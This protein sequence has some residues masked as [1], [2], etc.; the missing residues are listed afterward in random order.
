MSLASLTDT[1]RAKA[2]AN[3]SLGY[4]IQFDLGDDGIIFWD[5]TQEPAAI[6][7]ESGEADT[8][9]RLSA[10]DL[11]DLLAGNL[12]PTMA[13]MTGRL[14]VEGSLGVAMK[15]SQYMED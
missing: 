13:Y 8:T 5:G 9:I 2:T 14:K 7:N 15:I 12:N 1:V 3:P 4:R 6:G 11:E 10:D